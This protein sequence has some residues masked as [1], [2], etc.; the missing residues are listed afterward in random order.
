MFNP[1]LLKFKKHKYKD[2]HHNKGLAQLQKDLNSVE[3]NMK[4][5]MTKEEKAEARADS[6]SDDE[7]KKRTRKL[8]GI[9]PLK[10]KF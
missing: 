10:F 7:S 5:M 3:K 4:K 6:D 2:P 1:K 9:K 8:K